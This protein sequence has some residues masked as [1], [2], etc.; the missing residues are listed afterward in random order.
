MRCANHFD[1]L[2]FA[3]M[4][5]VH[6]QNV[7][8]NL[9]HSTETC[10][11]T[12]TVLKTEIEACCGIPALLQ[13]LLQGMQVLSDTEILEPATGVLTLV[14]DESPLFAWDVACNPNRDLL[15]GDASIVRFREESVDY[16]NV[17]TRAPVSQGIHFFEF[18]M[19]HV[20]DEQWCGVCLDRAR[21]GY[22][23]SDEGWFYYSGRRYSRRG[24]L[25][26]PRER[27]HVQDFAGVASGDIIGML[28]DVD[29]GGLVFLLN[30]AIQGS[31][32]VAARRPLFLCTSLDRA[33]DHVEL[34]KPPLADTPQ[35][36][37]Q[38]LEAIL[39]SG[40]TFA[41]SLS[42]PGLPSS[43]TRQT[44]VADN[45]LLHSS[46]TDEAFLSNDS[47]LEDP[48]VGIPSCSS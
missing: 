47:D 24:A 19:H 35:S 33:G 2:S 43:Q 44:P 20:G 8:G 17:V 36:A 16:V 22:H 38:A 31:C 6:V 45:E 15:Q 30:D 40:S 1:H 12:V 37:T 41:R 14:V 32:R 46:E 3:Q 9:V 7:A 13:Q 39:N 5:I 23:G 34:R 42:D 10:P 21:A 29:G 27:Q 11:L 48:E 28:L 26:A 18:V 25:H 4:P